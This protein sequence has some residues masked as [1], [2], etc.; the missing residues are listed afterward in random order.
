MMA[1]LAQAKG[2]EGY[3]V[4]LDTP[5]MMAVMSFAEDADLRAGASSLEHSRQRSGP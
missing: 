4:T 5:V 2:L 1:S 3:L